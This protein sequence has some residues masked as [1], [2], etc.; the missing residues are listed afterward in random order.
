MKLHPESALSLNDLKGA[1]VFK[2]KKDGTEETYR[3]YDFSIALEPCWDNPNNET[4]MTGYELS[5]IN[6]VLI[7]I[8]NGKLKKEKR[9]G[10]SF[11]NF[12]NYSIQLSRGFTNELE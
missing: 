5:D 11:D 1:F 10:Q 4:E 6:V 12:K 7:P 8:E 3:V 9:F 2:E